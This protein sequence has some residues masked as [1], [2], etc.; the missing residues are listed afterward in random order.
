VAL[1]PPT[2]PRRGAA[3][4]LLWLLAPLLAAA[5]PTA[6]EDLLVASPN[7]QQVLRY[8]AADG[9]FV[10]VLVETVTEGFQTPA[11][12]AVRPSGDLYV[13][14]AGSGEIWRYDIGT[15][16]PATPPEASGLIQPGGVGFDATSDFLYLV[17][18]ADGLSINRDSVKRLAIASGAISTVGTDAN[19]D[20]ANVAVNGARVFASNSLGGTVVS[21]STSGGNDTVEISGLL[22]PGALLF[23]S[24]TQLLVAETGTD[25]VLEYVE[26]SGNWVFDRVVLAASAGVDGPAGLA[27]A[28]DA[29]LTVSGQFSNHVVAVD[30][31]SLV[32]SELVAPGAGGLTNAGSVAWSGTTLLVASL[33]SNAVLGFDAVGTPLG[34]VARGLS[35][36]IDAAMGLSSRGTLTVGSSVTNTVVEY[37]ATGGGLVGPACPTSLDAP[38]DAAFGP[39][40]HLYVSCIISN[41]IHSFNTTTG[42]PMGFFVTPGTGGLF[43]PKGLAFGPNGNLF[44]ASSAT[45][46]ILEFD[47]ATGALVSTFVAASNAGAGPVGV[48]FHG[49][50]LYVSYAATDDVRA[51]DALDGTPLGVFVAAGAGGLDAPAGLDF[52]PDGNLYVASLD[53]DEVLQFDGA[54]GAFLSVFVAA[55]SGGLAGPI[56]LVF[57]PEPGFATGFGCG[58]AALLGLHASR[59]RRRRGRR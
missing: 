34:P 46:Q 28:P 39:D 40:G 55:G 47:G 42:F 18:P 15:G 5:T 26:S 1:L 31:T 52:G 37:A 2:R 24:A 21:F 41:G 6:A 48:L 51:Y 19:A 45:N 38:Y 56:D 50:A 30:L 36:P 58:L 49:G 23:R 29:R 10:D 9:S 27:L 17:D 44:V 53:T 33:A 13:A 14:S 22:S 7:T 20:Y 16:L 11:G 12:I 43:F 8:D 54:T 57:T 4:Q 59:R 35:P 3:R 25:R 32:V